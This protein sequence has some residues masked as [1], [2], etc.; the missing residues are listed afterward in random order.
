MSS[1]GQGKRRHYFRFYFDENGRAFAIRSDSKTSLENISYNNSSSLYNAAELSSNGT[2]S[3][4]IQVQTENEK[5]TIMWSCAHV[6]SRLHNI[7]NVV[8]SKCTKIYNV[9]RSSC[10][11]F[12]IVYERPSAAPLSKWEFSKQFLRIISTLSEW[13]KTL[14][15]F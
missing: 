2:G 11:I 14:T 15:L 5:Y 1:C 13:T 4:G 7:L 10:L 3:N 12:P 6:R 8:I 9:S